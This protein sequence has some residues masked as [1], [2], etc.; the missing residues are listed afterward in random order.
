MHFLSKTGADLRMDKWHLFQV[1]FSTL[2][3]KKHYVELN[4]NFNLQANSTKLGLNF[5]CVEMTLQTEKRAI[6]KINMSLSVAKAMNQFRLQL[7]E[8]LCLSSS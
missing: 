5:I 1:S 8:K 7:S 2:I 3:R 4:K 6:V